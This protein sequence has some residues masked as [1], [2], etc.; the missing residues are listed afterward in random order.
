[1]CVSDMAEIGTRCP[2]ARREG[3]LAEQLRKGEGGT[4][5]RGCPGP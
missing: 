3:Y 1:M 4:G 5:K 2:I